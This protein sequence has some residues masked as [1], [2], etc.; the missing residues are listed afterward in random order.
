MRAA[1]QT[2]AVRWRGTEDAE[3]DAADKADVNDVAMAE[4]G[5]AEVDGDAGREDEVETRGLRRREKG[6]E[7][8]LEED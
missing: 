3:A 8:V 4:A 7:E 2:F 1:S 6:R 5:G